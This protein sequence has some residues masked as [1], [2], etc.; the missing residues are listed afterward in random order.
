MRFA[1]PLNSQ[2]GQ[3][4]IHAADCRDLAQP[5]KRR[6]FNLYGKDEPEMIEAQDADAAADAALRAEFSDEIEHPEHK[7][8]PGGSFGAAGF[9]ARVFPCAKVRR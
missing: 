1:A 2:T 6:D 9:T 7:G 5:R 3:F 8:F 4:E